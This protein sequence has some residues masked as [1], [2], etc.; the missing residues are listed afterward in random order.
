VRRYIA[1]AIEQRG[2]AGP[3]EPRDHRHRY[4]CLTGSGSETV[5]ALAGVMT[6][7]PASDRGM[8]VA[9]IDIAQF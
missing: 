5:P 7:T 1:T 3:T 9:G 8:S 2:Y 6:V 4:Y